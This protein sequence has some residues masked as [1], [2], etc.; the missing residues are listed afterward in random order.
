MISDPKNS[1]SVICRPPVQVS[2]L[3]VVLEAAATRTSEPLHHTMQQGLPDASN[4]ARVAT[5]NDL[6]CW[7]SA[8]LYLP[9]PAVF[10]PE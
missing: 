10:D 1:I 5:R 3:E 6:L 9:A 4:C 2:N 7:Q 8:N